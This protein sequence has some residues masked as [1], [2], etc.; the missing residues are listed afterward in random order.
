MRRA[1]LILVFLGGWLVSCGTDGPALIPYPDR[2]S[3]DDGGEAGSGGATSSSSVGATGTSAST[4]TSGSTSNASSSSSTGATSSVASTGS[5][6]A[7][8]ATGG[9]GQ[10]I[11]DA[12]DLECVEC[13]KLNCCV[14]VLDC[15]DEEDCSCWIDCVATTLG[16]IDQCILQCGLPGVEILDL[17]DCTG[18]ECDI[19]CGG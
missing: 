3:D 5:V 1:T 7:T 14:E 16:A 13:A 12:D 8:T 9:G 19:E 11:P 15:T 10:C 18:L 2:S 17:L 4:G 6:G